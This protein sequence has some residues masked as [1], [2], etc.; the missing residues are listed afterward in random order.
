MKDIEYY[1]K[2]KVAFPKKSDFHSFQVNNIKEGG[3]VH[4]GLSGS[5]LVKLGFK[6]VGLKQET[7]IQEVEGVKYL[8]IHMFQEEAFKAA[9]KA[10]ES[11]KNALLEEFQSALAEENSIDVSSNVHQLVWQKAWE[12]GHSCG[13]YAVANHYESYADWADEIIKA[14]IKDLEPA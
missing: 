6:S 2:P 11:E 9:E 10:Y 13:L 3:I 14:N 7:D 5:E 4:K 1:S 12:D 8:V